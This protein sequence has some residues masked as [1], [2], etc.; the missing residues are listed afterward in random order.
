MVEYK[1]GADNKVADTLS[2]REEEEAV[3]LNHSVKAITMV[4]PIW[5]DAIKEMIS[6]SLFFQK[7]REK[8]QEGAK[9]NKHY[10]E[11]V[12]CCFIKIKFYLIQI[13]WYANK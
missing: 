8:L 12:A 13:L 3:N 10:K 5:V 7:S 1:R 9:I 4:E 6:S 2:R 11:K